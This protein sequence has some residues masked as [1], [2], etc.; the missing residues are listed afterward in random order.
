MILSIIIPTYNEIKHIKYCLDSIHLRENIEIII[1]DNNS[2]DGTWE[3]LNKLNKDYK[4]LRCLKQGV[5]FAR[6][7]GLKN[8]KGCYTFFLDADE[9]LE[10]NFLDKLILFIKNKN[11]DAITLTRKPLGTSIFSKIKA[12][13]IK[14]ERFI[15]VWKRS[16][17]NQLKGYDN[18]L[19]V[20]EDI[21]IQKRAKKITK[22]I[23]LFNK[24]FYHLVPNLKE[25]LS[26]ASWRGKGYRKVIKKYPKL[27]IFKLISSLFFITPLL[28]LL[29][30]YFNFLIYI[31]L[32]L[33]IIILEIIKIFKFFIMKK[34]LCVIGI[35]IVDFLRS[36]FILCG[37][38][39]NRRITFK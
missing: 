38:I 23:Y 28:F 13:G 19:E 25:E 20:G 15:R 12:S 35:P 22:K 6:N 37:F 39:F 2:K 1:V 31:I 7:L 17:L 30:I 33:P 34:N 16:I 32:V 36:L 8:S 14:N 18:T 24:K 10:D 9:I 11:P 27:V 26:C 3:Y 4:V 29:I 21:D 5:S